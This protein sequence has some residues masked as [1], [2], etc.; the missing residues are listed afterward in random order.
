MPP[1]PPACAC[2]PQKWAAEGKDYPL[3]GMPSPTPQET[4]AFVQGLKDGGLNVLCN[5]MTKD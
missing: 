1:G 3:V 4:Q 5:K 2:L